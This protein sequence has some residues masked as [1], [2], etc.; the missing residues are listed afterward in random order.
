MKNN[1]KY[2]DLLREGFTEKTLSIL[3]EKKIAILHSRIFSEATYKVSSD[4]VDQI[5]D[6]VDSD[7]TIEVTEEDET[8]EEELDE[9]SDF[10]KPV[11]ADNG[12]KQ[13]THSKQV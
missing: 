3:N 2:N 6:K 7:D 8:H 11:S 4:N 9:E 12:W 1:K 5:K 13:D 10:T